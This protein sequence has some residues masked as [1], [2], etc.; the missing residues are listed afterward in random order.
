MFLP[1]QVGHFLSIAK[2]IAQNTGAAQVETGRGLIGA[3]IRYVDAVYGLTLR[4]PLQKL[5][6]A[7]L[8]PE[9][10]KHP[11]AGASVARSVQWIGRCL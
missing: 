8:M 1:R 4:T 9:R 6:A 3:L 7:G 5:A 11:C 2:C 10:A